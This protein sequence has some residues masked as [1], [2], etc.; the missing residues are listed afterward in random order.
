[1]NYRNEFSSSSTG[2]IKECIEGFGA[3]LKAMLAAAKVSPEIPS[4]DLFIAGGAVKDFLSNKPIKD[5]DVFF[6]TEQ[7]AS[8]FIEKFKTVPGVQIIS[9][10][11]NSCSVSWAFAN[12]PA[13]PIKIVLDLIKARFGT[14]EQV[15]STFDFTICS[16][17]VTPHSMVFHKNYF[18]DLFTKSLVFNSLPDLSG[19]RRV[20][21]Y[22]NK[23]F[24]IDESELVRFFEY[25][26]L[27]G[28]QGDQLVDQIKSAPKYP[29][30]Q[31]RVRRL[32]FKVNRNDP[33]F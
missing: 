13:Q 27:S 11:D 15:I 26:L 18:Q 33:S 32:V 8:T 12:S 31:E 7:Q 25:N 10:S 30:Y 16:A 21:K 29:Q 9:E 17:A 6:R 2:I 3:V 19:L 1:M 23:G 24:H 28:P 20:L 14:P 22:V 4:G 5:L